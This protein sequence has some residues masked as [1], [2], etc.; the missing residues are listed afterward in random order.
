VRAAISW[1]ETRVSLEKTPAT[2]DD[3]PR[4]KLASESGRHPFEPCRKFWRRRLVNHE[5]QKG[6]CFQSV[7]IGRQRFLLTPDL[8]SQPLD[9]GLPR[10]LGFES[11]CFKFPA[12]LFQRSLFLCQAFGL[13]AKLQSESLQ[14]FQALLDASA[15]FHQ[16]LFWRQTRGRHHRRRL[17]VDL[18][19][20]ET[21]GGA[22]KVPPVSCTR[23]RNVPARSL[24]RSEFCGPHGTPVDGDSFPAGEIHHPQTVGGQH[25]AEVHR[26]NA[27]VLEAEFAA[28][29]TPRQRDQSGDGR[30]APLAGTSTSEKRD[31]DLRDRS[32]LTRVWV[33]RTEAGRRVPSSLAEM[34]RVNEPHLVGTDGDGFDQ[35]EPIGLARPVRPV[36]LPVARQIDA[37]DAAKNGLWIGVAV[38]DGRMIQSQTAAFGASDQC[39]GCINHMEGEAR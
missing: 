34:H 6:S 10:T 11:R 24:S 4:G 12:R 29:R 25:K 38:A 8:G 15:F 37:I 22:P 14:F 1:P 33:E 20:R 3:S 36:S 5:V 35:L 26:G 28:G 16:T 39:E 32:V 17:C 18:L 13:G 19:R 9:L 30:F 21:A 27:R 2:Y 23:I 31:L 7:A